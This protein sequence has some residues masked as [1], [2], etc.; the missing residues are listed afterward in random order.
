M[1]GIIVGTQGCFWNNEVG[2]YIYIYI[3]M[4]IHVQYIQTYIYIY[5]Y[6]AYTYSI[7]LWM[8]HSSSHCHVNWEVRR[9]E[10]R[11]MVSL[12]IVGSWVS[13]D[14]NLSRI[15]FR[16]YIFPTTISSDSHYATWPLVEVVQQCRHWV[17]ESFYLVACLS[18]FLKLWML[19]W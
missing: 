1:D 11:E 8:T 15:F 3:C 16:V 7:I 12:G 2:I 18:Q 9:L 17:N 5:I 10:Y 6:N 14:A 13:Q 4:Y 19:S